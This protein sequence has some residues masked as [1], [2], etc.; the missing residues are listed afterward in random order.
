[1][2]LVASRAGIGSLAP[3]AN[4]VGQKMGA[5]YADKMFGRSD[6]EMAAEF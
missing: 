1:M 2:A 5:N 6:N 3:M 4:L